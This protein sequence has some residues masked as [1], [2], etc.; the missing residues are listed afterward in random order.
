M[1][2]PCLY[3]VLWQSPVSSTVENQWT[4]VGC[5]DLFY[6]A[7][8]NRVVSAVTCR[9]EFAVELRQRPLE[10]RRTALG[11]AEPDAQSLRGFAVLLNLGKIFR[12][13]FLMFSK[14]IDPKSLLGMKERMS[15]CRPIDADQHKKRLER[16]RSERVRGHA[17]DVAPPIRDRNDRDSG[18]EMRKRLAESFCRR[19]KLGRLRHRAAKTL[20]PSAISMQ[21]MSSEGC[22]AEAAAATEASLGNIGFFAE[23]EP[24]T[25]RKPCVTLF[26]N[27]P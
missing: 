1:D 5:F 24:A 13:L 27:A 11:V 15:A 21:H 22:H 25:R 4:A 20:S 6:F 17:M 2:P 26:G 9:D 3:F 16:N 19:G 23:P 12:K 14:D 18:G 10:H 7:D 8:K